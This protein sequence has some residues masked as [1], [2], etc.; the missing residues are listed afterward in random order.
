M[1][2]TTCLEI[3][4][5][6]LGP[7]WSSILFWDKDSFLLCA[8]LAGLWVSIDSPIW[9]EECWDG[10]HL[11]PGF[12]W[13]LCILTHILKCFSFFSWQKLLKREPVY[14]GSQLEETGRDGEEVKAAGTEGA[15]HFTFIVKKQTDTVLRSVPPISLAQDPD[16]GND[17]THSGQVFPGNNT[18]PGGQV[19]PPHLT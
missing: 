16:L 5:Q 6:S 4:I 11:C 18:T 3:R 10:R 12:M 2:H 14:S 9:A 15:D 8:Q 1:D 19:F 7:L 17:T 13:V